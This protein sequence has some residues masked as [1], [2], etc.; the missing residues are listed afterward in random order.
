MPSLDE[1]SRRRGTLVAV[2][3]NGTACSNPMVETTSDDIPKAEPLTIDGVTHAYGATVAV[4]DVTLEVRGG[5]L[6][7]L[8][9]PSGCGKTTL[10][11]TIAGFIRQTRG[12][13]II[14]DRVVDDLPPNRREVGI[15]FQNYALFPHMTVADNI[16][17]GLA[18]RGASR[19]L[20]R[21][22]V[23][24]MLA[25]VRMEGFAERKPRQLSGGQQQRVALARALAVR[26]RILLLDEPFAALDKNLRLDM[27]IEIKRLQRRFALTA[28]LVTHDQEEAMSIADRIAV[29]NKGRVEQ[30]GSPVS[31]YD[32]PATL[33]VNSF[34][35]S[36]NLVSGR[37][38]ASNAYACKVGLVG[39][40]SWVV[41]TKGGFKAGD[42]VLVSVRPEQLNLFGSPA[43]DRLAVRLS[44]SLPIGG[45]LIHDVATSDG[46]TLKVAATRAPG[47]A[48]AE[49]GVYHCGLA[50]H[51]QPAIFAKPTL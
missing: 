14:G 51:A 32:E 1:A 33:F 5:E 9:G 21:A 26:P 15:V 44:L 31:I 25:T 46:A 23:A 41:P 24:E 37:V 48:V 40:A 27:Q 3:E 36:S 13:V 42:E 12:R 30:L 29:M 43:P 6:V 16:A 7:A 4:D 39:G 38:E 8:L 34:I 11:R 49:A 50:E 10:L 18:A 19:D 17:Y 20:Q 28:I 35:G 47:A 22:C 45:T 2:L